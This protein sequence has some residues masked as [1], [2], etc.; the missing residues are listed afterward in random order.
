LSKHL[1][2]HNLYVPV[3][4]AYRADHSTETALLKVV[5]DLLLTVDDGDAAVLA[6]LDQSSAFDTIDHS[7]L[8]HRL[9]ALF[10]I[11]GIVHSWFSSYLSGR[12]QSVCIA[13]VPSAAVLLLFGVPQGSVL[14]PILF[15]L[16][17]SP[18]H[19]ISQKHSVADHY[20]AD[21]D[22]K[23]LRFALGDSNSEQADQQRAFSQLSSCIAETKM[24]MADN[25]IQLNDPKTDALVV[26]SEFSKRKPAKIDLVV[27]AASITSSSSV[28]NLGVILDENLTM[29]QQ[30][31]KT[32]RSANFHLRRIAKVRK[33][34]SRSAT[35][36]LV[37][38]FVLSQMD[39]GNSLLAG[40]PADRLKPLKRV[41]LSAARVVTGARRRDRMT[42]HLMDLHWLPIPYRIDFKIAVLTY[43]CL[44][45]CAPSYLSSLLHRRSTNMGGRALRSASAPSALYDL[46]LPPIHIKSLGKRA[47]SSYAPAIWNALPVS[48]R[49]SSTLPSFRA[50]LKRHYFQDA[51]L[52]QSPR[53]NW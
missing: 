29:R 32:C 24:W 44:N 50:A 5:N 53:Y 18:I 23:Y 8:L 10:G 26:F 28:R 52:S 15:T 30:I 46:V 11:S 35:A 22:Q 45:G 39:Y 13:G 33:Y 41:Q 27:G 12:L 7:I 40:L 2:L 16:Y 34:L 14:G 43:R 36:Q 3:Q 31:T 47:F 4:S 25:F 42:P 49:S 48:V 21:D 19:S 38:A 37:S 17:N 9:N 1:I 51:F 20:Y 6:L